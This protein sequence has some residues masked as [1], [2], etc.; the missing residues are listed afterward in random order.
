MGRADARLAGA[1]SSRRGGG[2]PRPARVLS[3]GQPVDAA[4]PA[5]AE[6]PRARSER[7]D[8]GIRRGRR[9]GRARVAALVARHNLR[10][11][12]GDRR[13]ALR[14]CGRRLR[15]D[16]RRWLIARSTSSNPNDRARAHLHG[17]RL[18]AVL[19]RRALAALSRARALRPEVLADHAD[20]VEPAAGRPIPGS[21]GRP[22]RADRRVGRPRRPA[23]RA[24]RFL[25]A[26]G[27]RLSRRC[28]L[29]GTEP[30]HAARAHATRLLAGAD[31]YS[32]PRSTRCGSSSGWSRSTCWCGAHGSQRS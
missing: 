13:G 5:C 31:W 22:R 14:I 15:G 18:G 29:V 27:A 9:A 4:G 28:L 24:P 19:R 20:F 7:V 16:V 32:A 30:R 6:T 11:G 21:A 17:D 1:D 23:G 12:R 2:V 3:D 26:P 25:P 8:P 10:K